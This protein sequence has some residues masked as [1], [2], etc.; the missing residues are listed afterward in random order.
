MEFGIKWWGAS[1]NK[2]IKNIQNIQKK[3]AIRA[4]SNSRFKAHTI[5]LLEN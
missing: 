1:K 5:P 2:K 4:V 3:K